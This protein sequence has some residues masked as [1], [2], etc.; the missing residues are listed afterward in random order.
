MTSASSQS[1]VPDTDDEKDPRLE[2]SA[3]LALDKLLSLVSPFRTFE[4]PPFGTL[5]PPFKPLPPIKP[6]P[7]LTG[8]RALLARLPLDEGV[9]G[10]EPFD[11]DP[12][13]ISSKRGGRGRIW[14][15][16]YSPHLLHTCGK[17]NEM[18]IVSESVKGMS[19][20]NGQCTHNLASIQG[21]PSPTWRV[22]CSAVEA[23]S[24]KE[25]GLFA[26]GV[27]GVD[28]SNVARDSTEHTS[29]SGRRR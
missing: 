25:L 26:V 27:V 6:I 13:L 29:H 4:I 8:F 24:S 21:T 23:T 7:G 2:E 3:A 10:D 18:A 22:S 16:S 15:R 17:G 28:N 1:E 11:E 19:Q 5:P 14:V 12:V 9:A 20:I